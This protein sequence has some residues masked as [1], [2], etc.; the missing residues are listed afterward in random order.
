VPIV[1]NHDYDSAYPKKREISKFDHYFGPHRF[2]EKPWYGGSLNGSHANYYVRL[3]MDGWSFLIVALEFFPRQH[4]VEW[5]SDIIDA[6]PDAQ[7]I[8][9]THAYLNPDGTR[10]KRTDRW[11]ITRYGLEDSYSGE[12]LWEGLIKSKPNIL[13]VI[14]G[15]QPDGPYAAHRTDPGDAGNAVHQIFI[16]YQSSNRGDGWLGLLKFRPSLGNI[17]M[18][19]YRTYA[20][21]GLG[22]DPDAPT[23]SLPWPG[24]EQMSAPVN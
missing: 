18:S 12:E 1:G 10:T 2:E 13:A 7:S 22:F 17:E 5:A 4:A 16:D 6:H 15:H 23:Y 21:S 24:V 8:I 3:R 14:C 11:S 9:L 19:S 20:P